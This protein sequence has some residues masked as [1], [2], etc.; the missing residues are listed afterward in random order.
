ML[1]F[2]QIVLYSRLPCTHIQIEMYCTNLKVK[3]NTT[4]GIPTTNCLILKVEATKYISCMSNISRTTESVQY[5]DN[6]YG[7]ACHSTLCNL[8]RLKSSINKIP[9]KWIRSI[10]YT[11]LTMS[12]IRRN[13]QC[14]EDKPIIQAWL[15]I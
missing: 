4:A 14:S 7:Y 10:F 11:A 3:C 6:G 1:P 12:R 9:I 2:S 13:L 8:W 5:K 15:V